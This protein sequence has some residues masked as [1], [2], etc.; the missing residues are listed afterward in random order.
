VPELGDRHTM[1]TVGD[2][3]AIVVLESWLGG[4]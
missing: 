3:D 2:Q 4:R 1:M